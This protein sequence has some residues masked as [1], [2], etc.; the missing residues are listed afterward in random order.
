MSHPGN[1]SRQRHDQQYQQDEANN[2]DRPI[3]PSTTEGPDGQDGN[4]DYTDHDQDGTREGHCHGARFLGIQQGNELAA[5]MLPLSSSMRDPKFGYNVRVGAGLLIGL[6]I[7]L[8]IGLRVGIAL[9]STAS[10]KARA[11]ASRAAPTQD[12]AASPWFY[13]APLDR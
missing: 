8:L 4:E 10:G 3:S 5:E 12:S 11:V 7:D 2:D 6:L 9:A 1:A 13:I